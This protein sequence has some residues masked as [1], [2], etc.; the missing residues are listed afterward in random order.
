LFGESITRIP[1]DEDEYVNEISSKVMLLEGWSPVLMRTLLWGC[2]A[3]SWR[4]EMVI[5]Y[6]FGCMKVADGEA[7]YESSS[8]KYFFLTK[9][10]APG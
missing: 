3:G 6:I 7:Q 4:M 1:K 8:F 9:H 2:S 10:V 5:E